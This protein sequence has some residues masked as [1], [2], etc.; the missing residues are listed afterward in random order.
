MKYYKIIA[1]DQIVGTGR[2]FLKWYSKTNAVGYCDMNLAMFVMDD[3]TGAI[4][5]CDWLYSVPDGVGISYP[6]AEVALISELEYTDLF[7]QLTEGQPVSVPSEGEYVEPSVP[8]EDLSPEPAPKPPE[9]VPETPMSVQ[10]M[11]EK[12]AQQ[13][14]LISELTECIL[15]LSGKVYGE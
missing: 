8:D 10:Q 13:E 12:I 1:N 4:Y 11:R 6:K 2:Y 5:S 3:V 9:P 14:T 7:E 15:E